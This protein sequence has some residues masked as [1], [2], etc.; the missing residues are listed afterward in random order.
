MPNYKQVIAIIEVLVIIGLGLVAVDRGLV[1][2]LGF[3]GQQED[4]SLYEMDTE[5]EW[6]NQSGRFWTERAASISEGKLTIR[7]Y[8]EWRDPEFSY[9]SMA[10]L[11]TRM[12]NAT[13]DP[14][15]LDKLYLKGSLGNV[16]EET[17]IRVVL[18][19][20]TG[21]P[22]TSKENLDYCIGKDKIVYDEFLSGNGELNVERDVSNITAQ[23]FLQIE[24]GIFANTTKPLPP[25]KAPYV[26]SVRL[27]AE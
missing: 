25:N 20:C 24:L 4:S 7:L 12:I 10:V 17:G 22:L 21:F 14:I 19:D 26:D 11:R 13:Y 16:P 1:G 2:D 6:R 3:L 27:T 18:R 23:N 5:E 9:S 15:T 8:D